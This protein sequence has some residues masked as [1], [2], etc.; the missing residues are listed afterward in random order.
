[1]KVCMLAYS[2]YEGDNRV[3][4]YAETLAARGDH[5]DVVSLRRFKDEQD[6]LVNG[7]NV[8]RIQTRVRDE[9]SKL[10]YL[11]RLLAFLFRS[12]V[13]LWKRNHRTRYDLVHVH[14][15]PDFLVFA[16]L[17]LKL[18]GTKV[19]LDIHDILPELYSGKFG[20]T[21]KSL[22]FHALVLVERICST[23]ADHVIIANDLW[24]DRLIRR[25]TR[26]AKCTTIM[27]YPDR[28]IFFRRGRSRDD[29]RFLILYPGS[30]N[31]HQGLDLAIRALAQIRD[32][33]PQADL[34]IYG[35][36]PEKHSLSSLAL[37]L[38][39]QNRVFIH[40]TLPIREIARVME[41][42]DLAVV[43]KR[44]DSFGNEAF[45][46]KT[47]E[48][49]TLGVPLVVAATEIDR[50]YFRHS[51]VL[52]FRPGDV[53]ELAA[54]LLA[55][56]ESPRLRKTY[57]ERGSRFAAINEWEQKKH[58]YLEVVSRLTGELAGHPADI[59]A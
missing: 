18:T 41:N 4:R 10:T 47:L 38:G 46:T 22:M 49:M 8:V 32:V 29:D 56:I 15:V 50:L 59:L 5:V 19:I 51:E 55:M 48:F 26:P 24:H 9:M 31:R 20:S 28:N 44:S 27:N 43:P 40:D 30:L 34:H 6:S 52:F 25:S 16:A 54:S 35:S 21:R 17:P 33:S 3:M 36:G 14:S 39:L 13:E 7:V 23:V 53:D 11:F 37:E 42:A 45:S 12:T 57:I 1:M 2:F 58:L